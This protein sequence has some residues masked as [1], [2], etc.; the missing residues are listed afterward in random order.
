L[1]TTTGVVVVIFTAVATVWA[2]A[3]VP[4]SKRIPNV[5]VAFFMAFT[6]RMECFFVLQYL[7]CL[8][9]ARGMKRLRR[10]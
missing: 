1:L 7:L 4:A 5:V 6:D 3:C 2:N 9:E 8:H 10:R